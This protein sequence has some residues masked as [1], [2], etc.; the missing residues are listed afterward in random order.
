M[1]VRQA[2]AAA[3]PIAVANSAALKVPLWLGPLNPR[4]R[5]KWA[6]QGRE[7]IRLDDLRPWGAPVSLFHEQRRG[8]VLGWLERGVS[9][10]EKQR[11]QRIYPQL[12]WQ[13]K[14][15]LA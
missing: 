13:E 5:E 7:V 6:R 3:A 15:P 8:Q 12:L 14:G 2:E 1:S 11:W 9:S 10:A 4:E